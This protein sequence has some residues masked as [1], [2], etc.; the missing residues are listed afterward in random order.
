MRVFILGASETLWLSARHIHL[1][2]CGKIVGVLTRKSSPLAGRT[3]SDFKAMSEE[4]AADFFIRE[5]FDDATKERIL[6]SQADLCVALG[7][8]GPLSE[9]APLFRLG[10][11][12]AV[13]SA[14]SQQSGSDLDIWAILGGAPE[15]NLSIHH[16]SPADGRVRKLPFET[17]IGL[18]SATTIADVRCFHETRLPTLFC[19]AIES[20]SKPTFAMDEALA[21]DTTSNSHFQPLEDRDRHINWRDSAAKIHAQI[22]AFTRPLAGAYTY[23]RDST[24][25]MLRLHIWK[26]RLAMNRRKEFGH[27]GQVSFCDP[28]SGEAFVITNEGVLALQEVSESVDGPAFEPGKHWAKDRVTLGLSLEDEVFSLISRDTMFR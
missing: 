10:A 14:G 27:C 1:T 5:N 11:I 13:Y 21:I 7:W 23:M 8:P 12:T 24:G 18:D 6:K 4:F 19:K 15:L 3:E 28:D 16:V 20:M 22:R 2:E 9:A 26:S 17:V 25:K